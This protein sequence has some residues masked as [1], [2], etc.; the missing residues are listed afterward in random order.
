MNKLF[1]ISI[2]LECLGHSYTNKQTTVTYLQLIFNW[3]HYILSCNSTL[4][5]TAFERLRNRSCMRYWVFQCKSSVGWREDSFID[6]ERYREN[7]TTD[8]HKIISINNPVTLIIM[9]PILTIPP[10]DLLLKSQ[11]PWGRQY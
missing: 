6:S 4:R 1:S 11:S 2:S 3:E 10:G 7:P 8:T 5:V 9:I